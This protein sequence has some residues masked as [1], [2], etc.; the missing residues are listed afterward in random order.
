LFEVVGLKKN[1]NSYWQMAI[2]SIVA[3]VG[4]SMMFFMGR[5]GTV[6]PGL[7]TTSSSA[8]LSAQG[9]NL[10]GG[11]TTRSACIAQCIQT[12]DNP[13]VPPNPIT[14]PIEPIPI[15]V[16]PIDESGCGDGIIRI[17]VNFEQC[18]GAE[19]G[20]KSCVTQGFL[21]GTLSCNAD[22]TFN[23]SRCSK[24]GD[25]IVDIGEECDGTN[26]SNKNCTTE[27]FF[28]GDLSCK[29]DCT[30]NT[31][32]CSKCGDHILNAGEQCD[33]N[34]YRKASGVPM[35]TTNCEEY[36]PIYASG[37]LSCNSNCVR[38]TYRCSK[39]GNGALDDGESC[40]LTA[41]PNK[42][43]NSNGNPMSGDTCRTFGFTT[44]GGKLTCEDC[45]TKTG[46]CGQRC[47]DNR[48][49]Q[50]ELCDGTDLNDESCLT[51]GFSRG[52]LKCS[53]NCR[54]FD[55]SLCIRSGKPVPIE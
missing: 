12:C 3:I 18:D 55:T 49:E 20:G 21:S 10:A 19:L 37:T 35:S 40:D 41:S 16:G 17:G 54:S 39:C 8:G 46:D 34:K 4:I 24:C 44:S 28:R 38:L 6:S 30:F 27:G 22:C 33:G 43:R 15:I 13:Q 23:T 47:G 42:Y 7:S 26:L 32:K 50:T 11:A 48:A 45:V 25:G 53:A 5:T 29:A 51:F 31:T 1:D 9:Y 14:D 52:T 36:N 2:V